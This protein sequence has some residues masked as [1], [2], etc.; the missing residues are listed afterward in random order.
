MHTLI[1]G[2][3]AAGM[4]ASI[5]AAQNGQSVTVLERGRKPLKKLG[6]T[7]NGRGNL[8]NAGAPDYP[9]GADFAAQV[10][11][12]MSYRQLAAF[13]DELGVPLRLEEEGR[14]Y[15]ASFMASTAVDALLLAARRLG[16]EIVLNA[17]VTELVRL[18]GGGFEARGTVCRYLPDV[19]KKSGKTRPGALAE[20]T[21]ARWRGDRIIVAAGGA[22]APVHGTDGSAYAL[23]TTFGHRLS[24]TRPALCALLADPEPLRA[25]AGQRVR[26]SLRLLNAQATC[27]AQSRGEVLFAQDG[28]SGIAAMQLARWWQPGCSL[29][30]DLREAVLGP[31]A[32]EG[33]GQRS[34]SETE[35]LLHIRAQRREGCSLG[36]LLTGAAPSAL[37]EMLL[38]SA[39]LSKYSNQSLHDLLS[40]R[41]QALAA[42]ARAIT[43]L[44]M[45]VTGTR[46]FD[47]AQVTA[48]GISTD[49]FDPQSLQSRL[50]PGLY[51][52]GEILDVDG[53]CGGFN[54]MFAFASGL[55]AG[56]AK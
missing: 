33:D 13:W 10:L 56:D 7:G 27:L 17:R 2:G 35:H 9:G 29:S 15:P 31:R 26:T 18:P 44:R 45:E 6:V 4:A 1:V 21:P 36:E 11:S 50:C 8:L 20:E 3:G 38:R 16:V 34:I 19:S 23:L 51:A 12:S 43:D 54:L 46:G 42:L 14:I 5:A 41:P 22:A 40:S 39:G 49:E 25:L 52:A 32:A 55:L 48:G 24:P 30:M 28:I 47:A 53:A 37:N